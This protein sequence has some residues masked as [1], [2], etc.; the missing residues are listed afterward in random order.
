M[1]FAWLSC[2][3]LCRCVTCLTCSCLRDFFFNALH[4]RFLLSHYYSKTNAL[5]D[6][7][8]IPARKPGTCAHTLRM[9]VCTCAC[10]CVCVCGH[11]VLLPGPWIAVARPV[12]WPA[13]ACDGCIVLWWRHVFCT[14]VLVIT[15][16]IAFVCCVLTFACKCDQ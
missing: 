3:E 15:I 11:T 14:A 7:N 8:H 6:Y 16:Q 10:T 12:S 9:R 13:N 4:E 5:L 2:N 1:A